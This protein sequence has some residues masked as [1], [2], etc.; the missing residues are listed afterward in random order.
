MSTFI[1]GK[2]KFN[3]KIII[4]NYQRNNILVFFSNQKNDLFQNDLEE[5]EIYFNIA[6]GYDKM[7]NLS[8]HKMKYLNCA[9]SYFSI[10]ALKIEDDLE[11]C[12]KK[13]FL[14]ILD[15]QNVI[16]EIFN[17]KNVQQI[18]YYHTE[19]GNEN[20]IDEYELVNWNLEDFANKF[21][22][23]IKNNKGFTPTIK[24]VFNK[25]N[26]DKNNKL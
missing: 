18:T 9:D 7:V 13:L 1:W 5:D 3:K 10:N 11:S 25:S 4:D 14:R 12:F 16:K 22:T 23:E 15:L 24:I 17:N 20:S 8:L 19:S 26:N 21:F 2:I 6:C